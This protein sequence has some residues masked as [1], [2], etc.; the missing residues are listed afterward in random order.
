M[1]HAQARAR[2]AEL[3]EEIRRHDHL[4]YVAARP[5]VTDREYDR[6]YRELLDLERAFP[7]LATAGSPSQRVG[8]Q[9]LSEFKP[10]QHLAPMM[11]LDNTYSQEEVREFVARVQKLLPGETLDWV[12]EP[13][14]DGLAV[15][16]R[17]EDGLFTVGATRGD[18]TTGDDITA[19]LRTLRSIPLRLARGP[20]RPA[21]LEVRGEVY[22]N[23]EVFRRINEERVSAGEEPFANPRNAAAGSLKQLDPSIVAKRRLDIVLYGTGRTEGGHPP[24]TQVELL[25][26]LQ[27]LGFRAPEKHWH[28]R[29]VEDLLAAITELDGLRDQFAYETDGAV[30]KLNSILLRE[31]AGATA[32]APRWG[33]AYKYA[34]D[35]AETRLNA[36]TIQVGRTGKLTPVAELEP[37]AL[38]GSTVKRATLHNE[39]QIGRLDVRVGDRVIIQ[40]AGE[41]IPEVVRVVTERRQ[42]DEKL[43]HFP[44]ACP[45]CGSAVA[46]G[47]VAAGAGGAGATTTKEAGA[48][49]E[50]EAA[51]W[52][53]V[54]PDCPAQVRGRIEHWCSRGAMDIE[55]GGEVLAT[56]LVQSGLAHDVADLYRLTEAEVAGLERMGE[57]S[58]RNFLAGLAASKSRDA[59]RLLFGLGIFHVGSGVA[60]AVMRRFATLEDL[61]G[62]SVDQLSEVD[63][64]GGVIAQSIVQWHGDSR[65]SSLVKRLHQAGLN[66]KSSLFAAGS[67]VGP[68]AGQTF[69]LTGT[70]PSLTREAASA[71]IEAL[72]G[73]VSGSVSKKTHFLL[74]GAEA[75]SKLEK[76]QKLGV[77]ILEEPAFLQM[78]TKAEVERD[79]AA[80]GA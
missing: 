9:P 78:C 69:V 7:E 62:A 1:T 18:G 68:F 8:G 74:A 34:P 30:I 59:W 5:V 47:A 79:A 2:H 72:G 76:A 3:A 66:F 35:Q 65:N 31:R 71:R 56:Q 44:K 4:Y 73:K 57:K 38:A 26:W 17:Y 42:G 10:S 41:I 48:D 40:K 23:K 52:R 28:C 53:C 77:T 54:N 37:V 49:A 16:L 63:D 12:V 15:N 50:Q 19:N 33:M 13:K 75:G 25:G 21:V 22:L 60:K 32:K 20:H 80:G 27:E 29:G 64:V 46:K 51:D 58:A 55:G 24:A 70:L 14:V 36:I 61:F 11:S 43:F 45:E 67:A 39:D 6:L